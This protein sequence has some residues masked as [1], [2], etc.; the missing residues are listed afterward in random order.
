M[1]GETKWYKLRWMKRFLSSFLRILFLTLFGLKFAYADPFQKLQTSYLTQKTL[2]GEA[3]QVRLDNF[4][5]ISNSNPEQNQDLFI[6][7]ESVRDFEFN[8]I[9]S[10]WNLGSRYSNL[11]GFQLW[12]KEFKTQYTSSLPQLDT[13]FGFKAG[14]FYQ[15]NLKIDSIWGLG[16]IEPQFRGDPLIPLHQGLTGVSGW[17]DLGGVKFS[18]FASPLSFPDTGIAY[19]IVDGE[20]VSNSP[21][22]IQAPTTVIFQGQEVPL[23]YDLNITSR[24]DLLLNTTLIGSV[25]AKVYGWNFELHGGV[26]PS[27]QFFLEVDPRGRFNSSSGQS[28]VEANVVPRLVP[29]SI[30]ALKLNKKYED[31]TVWAEAYSEEHQG[32][33]DN[34]DEDIY[35]SVIYDHSFV[36]LGFDSRL[37]FLQ[38]DLDF[39]VSYLRNPSRTLLNQFNRFDFANY[40]FRNAFETR[41]AL[42][43]YPSHFNMSFN[44]K[45]DLDESS[46]L[47]SPRLTYKTKDNIEVY[48]QYDLVG[49]SNSDNISG[50]LAEQAANDRFTVGLNYVF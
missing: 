48:S 38:M 50:F 1:L 28:F 34:S 36:A 11:E 2:S 23:S 47:A 49:R 4:I 9:T 31:T 14:R 21:W 5:S 40:I 26:M 29:K 46:F 6:A 17:A 18:L 37:K 3:A 27:S 22:F 45:Y 16:A 19:E 33:A 24:F 43:L 44:F 30:L 32:I 41:L 7:L 25:Q 20:V 12:V 10:N 8:A 35:Q 39:G 13:K 42:A 15:T